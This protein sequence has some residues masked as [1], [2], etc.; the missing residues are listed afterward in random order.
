MDAQLT[1]MRTTFA[2]E[3]ST[4]RIS[5]SARS[6]SGIAPVPP[7]PS[8]ITFTP[9]RSPP[10]PAVPCARPRAAKARTI[11]TQLHTA[12]FRT[13]VASSPAHKNSSLAAAQTCIPLP[14]FSS[15]LACRGRGRHEPLSGTS[16]VGRV[17]ARRRWIDGWARA[18]ADPQ[19]ELYYT[20]HHVYIGIPDRG[21]VATTGMGRGATELRV[22]REASRSRSMTRRGSG[23]RSRTTV[24]RERKAALRP[25]SISRSAGSTS[26]TDSHGRRTA[27]VC[28]R[29]P[30]WPK[31]RS[32]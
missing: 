16:R 32:W 7:R 14:S 29:K 23:R 19:H 13:A 12:S 10:R 1:P 6:G 26:R 2:P 5:R 21:A 22:G 17:R 27:D 20:R 24:P 25:R 8:Q 3:S 9:K 15:R 31:A 18:A 30:S 11:A 4:S 28:T